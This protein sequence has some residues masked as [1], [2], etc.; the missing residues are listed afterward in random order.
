[1]LKFTHS[2]LE[3]KQYGSDFICLCGARVW[4]IMWINKILSLALTL[5]KWHLLTEEAV[6]FNKCNASDF[7]YC[8][9]LQAIMQEQ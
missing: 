9:L 5:F 1:M 7:S 8:N 6:G 2:I 4:K 3:E